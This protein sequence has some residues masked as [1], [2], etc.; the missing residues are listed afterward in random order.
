[1]DNNLVDIVRQIINRIDLNIPVV[2]VVNGVGVDKIFV[3]NTMHITIGK[4]VKDE[5]GNEYKVTDFSFNEWVEVVPYNHLI[6][7]E[8]TVLVA[9]QILFLHGSPA[10][11]NNEYLLVSQRT[12]NKTPF[13]WLLESYEYENLPLDSSVIASYDARLFFMDWANT[14]KWKNDQHNSLVIKPME[15]LSKA[16]INVIENDYTFKR[17]GS[18]KR[19]PRP[20]F[21]VEITDKGSDKTIIHEDLSG[22]DMSVTLEMFNTELCCN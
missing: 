20:R 17:L 21:G 14:P 4:I 18:Y 7:F 5:F 6:P 8:S 11:T 22:V 16:F 15:N 12:L 2:S 3:C 13:I 10:S 19:R 1:M 9:P